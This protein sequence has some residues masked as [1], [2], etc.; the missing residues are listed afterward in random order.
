M[1]AAT[2]LGFHGVGSIC[3]TPK[4]PWAGSG[5]TTN[6]NGLFFLFSEG[7]VA[8]WSDLVK[9]ATV[10]FAIL[11]D[12]LNFTGGVSPVKTHTADCCIV[13]GLY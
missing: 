6:Q 10:C 13:S 2:S 1:A 4:G 11:T 9:H 3:I 5:Q 8:T 12:H 7:L